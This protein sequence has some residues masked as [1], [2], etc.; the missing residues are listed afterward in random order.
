MDPKAETGG[1][2][3]NGSTSRSSPTST[4]TASPGTSPT[5]NNKLATPPAAKAIMEWRLNQVFGGIENPNDPI[6]EA[7]IVSAV[8]FDSTGEYL[9]AG[10]KGGR[11]VMFKKDD[12][13][14]KNRNRADPGCKVEFKF[15]QEFQSHVLEFDCLK[16]MDI[17]EK[18]N[19][20]RFLHRR[21]E[22]HHLLTTNDKTIKLWK[23]FERKPKSIV[24]SSSTD[25]LQVPR[26]TPTGESVKMA[27]TRFVYSNAHTFHIHSISVN[28]D[29]ETFISADD[30]RINLWNLNHNEQ[31]FNIVDIK[32]PN[33]EELAEVI[34]CAEFHPSH[35]S[36]F[37][38][39]SSRGAIRLGDLR[40][41]SLCDTSTVRVF[42]E[43]EDTSNRSF[44]ADVTMSISDLKFSLD[45]RY[46]VSRDFMTLKLW[47][48]NMDSR[49]VKVVHVHD[50]LKSKLTDL[51][52][53]ENIFDKFECAVNGDSTQMMTGSYG[54]LFRTFEINGSNDTL[55]HANRV[56]PKPM[57][58]RIPPQINADTLDLARKVVHLAYHPSLNLMAITCHNNL[59]IFTA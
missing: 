12:T 58:K 46:L 35:C 14:D 9:A 55:L 59:F 22:A 8:Q 52:E 51:Y 20:I 26:V 34:T 48:I 42:E 44:F 10:D 16:S 24:K 56:Q 23:V 49:P 28:S 36:L 13:K 54:R 27:T 3:A 39:S 11:I 18:I 30:L 40:Q 33:M 25:G 15:C 50:Y 41:S 43:P 57:P 31:T 7:D 47:D 6:P 45:G 4:P 1:T 17:E 38:Y 37:A 53:S 5:P 29:Q 32:P 19:K 2:P 21:A